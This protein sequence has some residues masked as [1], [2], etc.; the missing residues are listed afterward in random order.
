MSLSRELVK[1]GF[2]GKVDD[3]NE[4]DMGVDVVLLDVVAISVEDGLDSIVHMVESWEQKEGRRRHQ[5]L[6]VYFN[7]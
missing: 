4:S 2:E 7:L 6:F 3:V 1:F 5:T